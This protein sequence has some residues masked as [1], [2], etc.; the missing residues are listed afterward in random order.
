MLEALEGGL[1]HVVVVVVLSIAKDLSEEEAYIDHL[2]Y[3]P[4]LALRL[5]GIGKP[6]IEVVGLFFI[7]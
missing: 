7:S 6:P 1:R 3:Q 2:G 5:V 4:L